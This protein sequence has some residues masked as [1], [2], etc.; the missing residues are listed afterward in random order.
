MA[1]GKRQVRGRRERGDRMAEVLAL[2]LLQPRKAL[3]PGP[4]TLEE[5][6]FARDVPGLTYEQIEALSP[7]AREAMKRQQER[8][9]GGRPWLEIATDQDILFGLAMKKH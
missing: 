3:P 2:T 9:H 1:Q 6:Q 7:E 4:C 5:Y 8:D